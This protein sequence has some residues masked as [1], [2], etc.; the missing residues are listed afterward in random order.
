MLSFIRKNDGDARMSTVTK[1]RDFCEAAGIDFIPENGGGPG[2]RLNMALDA[3][4][5][6][7]EDCAQIARKALGEG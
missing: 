7:L 1:L 2:V 4:D 6:M 3:I 5:Q